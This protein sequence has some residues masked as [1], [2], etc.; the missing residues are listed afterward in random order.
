MVSH[1]ACTVSFM[2]S[3]VNSSGHAKMVECV[4]HIYELEET[5]ALTPCLWVALY[6]MVKYFAKNPVIAFTSIC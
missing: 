4:S 3:G 6:S 2:P 5:G 1:I